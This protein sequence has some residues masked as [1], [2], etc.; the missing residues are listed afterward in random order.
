[1][2]KKKNWLEN[3]IYDVI[4]DSY[5]AEHEDFFLK[6]SKDFKDP[7]EILSRIRPFVFHAVDSLENFKKTLEPPKCKVHPNAVVSSWDLLTYM[8][9]VW[10]TDAKMVKITKI[11]PFGLSNMTIESGNFFV[12][13]DVSK[14]YVRKQKQNNYPNVYNTVDALVINT[15]FLLATNH[16]VSYFMSSIL[17][18][19]A[20]TFGYIELS[21]EKSFII[22]ICRFTFEENLNSLGASPF[23]EKIY[24]IRKDF[25]G[26]L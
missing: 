16:I 17:E 19:F 10:G 7:R 14:S 18:G 9:A 2:N 25:G 11:Y 13:N 15:N 5:M 3:S 12:I 21:R 26:P 6:T 24:P 1:M 20:R 4:L 22:E 23:T 8:Y